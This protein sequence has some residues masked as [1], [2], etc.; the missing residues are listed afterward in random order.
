MND[1]VDFANMKY[2]VIEAVRTEGGPECMVIGYPDEESLRD[3]IAAPSI[4]AL[5]FTSRDLAAATIE[6]GLALSAGSKQMPQAGGSAGTKPSQRDVRAA[7]RRIGDWFSVPESRR[8]ACRV[9]QQAL[10]T[11][12][13]AFYSRNALSAAIR[14]FFGGSF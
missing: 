14:T 9:M 1:R 13:L 12:I 8:I 10:A 6:N 7:K 4:V 5:G 3:L 11:A 2:A